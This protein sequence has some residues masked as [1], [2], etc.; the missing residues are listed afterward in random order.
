MSERQPLTKI[1]PEELARVF[2]T[3]GEQ[4]EKFLEGNGKQIVT[5]DTPA[6]VVRQCAEEIQSLATTIVEGI[7]E[8]GIDPVTLYLRTTQPA[9]KVGK[10][11]VG[12]PEQVGLLAFGNHRYHILEKVSGSMEKSLL[13]LLQR[14]PHGVDTRSEV[15]GIKK[16]EEGEGEDFVPDEMGGIEVY[17]PLVDD[18]T[19]HVNDQFFQPKALEGLVTIL[20]GDNHHHVKDTGQ[21]P[22]RVLILGGCG[23]G[24]GTKTE[25]SFEVS[26]FAEISRFT[27]LG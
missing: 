25:Q 23:F 6:K 24:V 16:A 17:L 2:P 21:G 18:I 27:P 8:G 14:I 10:I 4:I 3:L 19:F 7:R 13:L 5:L 22:T 1:Y 12:S 9:R 11:A 15:H 26:E 20:P